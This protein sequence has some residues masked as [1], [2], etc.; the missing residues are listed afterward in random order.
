MVAVSCREVEFFAADKP[1]LKES[2]SGIA[3]TSLKKSAS[4]LKYIFR[5]ISFDRIVEDVGSLYR[6]N[7]C[8]VFSFSKQT[9]QKHNVNKCILSFYKLKLRNIH[10]ALNQK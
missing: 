2:D 3:E 9:P 5:F 7:N 8:G 1:V 6:R 10:I 4:D